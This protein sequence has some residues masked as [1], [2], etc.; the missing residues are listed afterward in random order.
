MTLT[1]AQQDAIDHST[2]NLQ[3]VACAGSGK[4]EVVA[5]HVAALLDPGPLAALSP[6]NIVAFTFTEKA[7]VELKDRIIRRCRERHGDRV[8]VARLYVGTIHGF[9]L[10]LLRA[11]VPAY[12]EFGVLNAVQQVLL[13]D[14]H[15]AR[16]GLTTTTDL[17][18]KR[19]Q[20]FKDTRRYLSALDVLREARVHP[21][22][23]TTCSVAQGL[24]HY[25]ELLASTSSFDYAS[26]LEEAVRVLRHDPEVRARVSQRVRRLIVD[27]YQDV[28]P[29]QEQLIGL[30]H[31]LGATLCVVGD[32]DQTLYQW[33]GADVRNILTFARRYPNVRQV[34]L[35][36]NFRSSRG[37]VE[38]AR[39]FISR[40]AERLPKAMATTDAQP[41]EPGDI[42]ALAFLDHDAEATF[43]ARK[44]KELRGIT[45]REGERERA[46][47]YSDVAI[48]LR[49]VKATG[50]VVTQALDL[51]GI[52]YVVTG[53]NN[54]FEAREARAAR[55]LFY[56]V[57]G[58]N[59]VDE[60]AL[61]ASWEAA[62]LGLDTAKLDV[63]IENAAEARRTLDEPD[64]ER[65]GP[66]AISGV[67]ARFLEDLALREDAVPEKRGEASFY[68]LGKFREVIADFETIHGDRPP[69]EQYEE[70]AGFL[71]HGAE[72][73]YPEGWKEHDDASPDVVRVTTIHQAKGMQWPVVFV[74]ALLQN[75]F[76]SPKMGGAGVWHLIPR[77]AVE[78][79]ARYEGSIEDERRLF[80]VALTRAEK[81]LYLTWA[82]IPGKN[83]RYVKPSEFWE[84][85]LESKW[86]KRRDV[87]LDHRPRRGVASG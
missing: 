55:A 44:I 33:R 87:S 32:D 51:A 82:P 48:L 15:G 57:A 64:P 30:L 24:A 43:I 66:L 6:A 36:E 7:S 76:P 86:V 46:L 69:L 63:A 1:R 74:P 35:E 19:L 59:D 27:E 70:F 80:Y 11:E 79:Q 39:D 62:R 13:V 38:V 2:G 21:Q 84:Q 9:C 17:E 61:K 54:L 73:A 45:Y 78:D 31:E 85:V 8:N 53:M 67:F 68:N 14:R 40:N 77:A 23:L 50:G 41:F 28:N 16:S 26:I 60:F 34:R 4:T 47:S 5:R 25:R 56:F 10:D 75:R 20:R 71:E 42:E 52:P 65:W 29:V 72:G 49:S 12:G 18:G 22:N 58:H 37:I 81:F 3:L 83:S